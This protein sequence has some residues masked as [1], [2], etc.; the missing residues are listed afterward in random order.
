[1]DNVDDI[2]IKNVGYFY[3]PMLGFF[4]DEEVSNVLDINIQNILLHIQ[5]PLVQSCKSLN[6]LLHLRNEKG[7]RIGLTYWKEYGYRFPI[8]FDLADDSNS[9]QILKEYIAKKQYE[10]PEKY[11]DLKL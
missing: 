8:V 1:M 10:K 4:H 2:Y 6:D 11:G 3:R 7:E 5:D 9:L